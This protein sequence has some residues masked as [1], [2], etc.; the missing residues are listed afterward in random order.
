MG[1]HLFISVALHKVETLM[2]LG[3]GSFAAEISFWLL[4]CGTYMGGGGLALSASQRFLLV[5]M[6][7]WLLL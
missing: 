1:A 7:I 5:Y 6:A 4:S 2:L 3:R